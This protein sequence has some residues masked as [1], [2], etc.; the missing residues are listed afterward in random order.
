MFIVPTSTRYSYAGFR[1]TSETT[2]FDLDFSAGLKQEE[3][4]VVGN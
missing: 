4:I 2:E 3:V 1:E